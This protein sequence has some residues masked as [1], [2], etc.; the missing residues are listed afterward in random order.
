ML[1]LAFTA[2]HA[3]HVRA[4]ALAQNASVVLKLVFLS[5][6]LALGASKLRALESPATEPS[7]ISA[8]AV[9]L[10]W[11]SFSY[12]GW[13]AAIYMSSEIRDPARNAPRA[14]LLGTAVVALVYLAL[15]A[16]IVFSAPVSAL[17]GQVDVA[18][19]AARH[20]GGDNWETAITAIVALA[21]ATSVSSL[22]MSGPRVYARM[23]LDGYLPKFLASNGASPRA[24]IFFQTAVALFLL[25]TTTFKALLTY[26]G[27]ILSLSTAATVAG[28][29]PLKIREGDKLHAPG[30]PWA[31]VLF[32]AFVLFTAA[33]TILR[34]PV[35]AAWG[36]LTLLAGLLAYRLQSAWRNAARRE[37]GPSGDASN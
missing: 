18:R 8:F 17:E 20:L 33:F 10:V 28:L 15:N 34:Q 3:W 5:L 36:G 11:I 23:A 7:S 31:P 19:I 26:I 37:N 35:E 32:I 16:L 12:S 29:I 24:A 14:M 9:S 27:F 1:I 22:V 2:A 4:G 21:L 25:W 6:F 13:N 30:W